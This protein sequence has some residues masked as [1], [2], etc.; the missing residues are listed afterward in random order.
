[1]ADES[2]KIARVRAGLVHLAN[3]RRVRQALNDDA[4]TAA[5]FDFL[6]DDRLWPPPPHHKRKRAAMQFE[7]D[8]LYRPGDRA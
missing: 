8:E 5:F 1:M 6:H 4:Y 2:E 3:I 7:V